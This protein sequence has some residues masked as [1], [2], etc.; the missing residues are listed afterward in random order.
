MKIRQG[1]GL[2]NGGIS[3]DYAVKL[4]DQVTI[5]FVIIV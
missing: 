1:I 3:L 4:S 2:G 5:L